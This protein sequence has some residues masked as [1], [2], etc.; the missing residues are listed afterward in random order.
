MSELISIPYG[1][2]KSKNELEASK[3]KM[4]ISIPY[5]AIKRIVCETQIEIITLFQFLMVRL[6]AG[7]NP[8]LMFQNGTFQFLMVRL[9]VIRRISLRVWLLHFNS[10]WCD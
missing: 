7:L 9:K 10:L 4:I 3:F 8:A 1:A 5:G 2:I 6:K